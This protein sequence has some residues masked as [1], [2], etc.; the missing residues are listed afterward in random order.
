G[1]HAPTRH[2]LRTDADAI[3]V[4]RNR[5][6]WQTDA[7]EKQIRTREVLRGA[8]TAAEGRGGNREM[9]A[10][11]RTPPRDALHWQPPCRER[12]SQGARVLDASRGIGASVLEEI[13]RAQR[14]RSGLPEI[15]IRGHPGIGDGIDA[16]RELGVGREHQS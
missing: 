4:A 13:E 10:L 11:G 8:L 7:A 3:E 1:R 15:E 9:M 2:L 5:R 12:L 14:E 16:L 6:K